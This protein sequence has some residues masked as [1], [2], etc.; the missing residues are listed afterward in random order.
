MNK[1]M[2]NNMKHDQD[3]TR[4]FVYVCTQFKAKEF[5]SFAVSKFE[6]TLLKPNINAEN[7]QNND[8]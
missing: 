7:K 8:Y 5:I 2:K 4:A 1:S 3:C 6:L